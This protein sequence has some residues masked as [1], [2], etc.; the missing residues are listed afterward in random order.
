VPN[1]ATR[2][3]REAAAELVENPRYRANLEQRLIAGKLAPAMEA[4]LWH[5]AYGK[6]KESIEIEQTTKYDLKD[7]KT[8]DRMS[9]AELK[10]ETIRAARMLIEAYEEAEEAKQAS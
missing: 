9:D 5:F 7:K 6:P 4:L 2:E 10:A 1:T 3:V 8:L